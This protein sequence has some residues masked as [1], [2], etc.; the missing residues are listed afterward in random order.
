MNG[1]ISTGDFSY[2]LTFVVIYICLDKINQNKNQKKHTMKTKQNLYVV[3]MVIS[4]LFFTSCDDRYQEESLLKNDD[5]TDVIWKPVMSDSA[6][7]S[8]RHFFLVIGKESY[9][10]SLLKEYGLTLD[11]VLAYRQQQY[12]LDVPDTLLKEIPLYYRGFCEGYPVI[13]SNENHHVCCP[14]LWSSSKAM[15]TLKVVD[16]KTFDQATVKIVESDARLFWQIVMVLAF[17]LLAIFLLR[18]G[19]EIWPI[20]LVSSLVLLY[21]AV[22]VWYYLPY[23]VSGLLSLGF[24]LSVVW[25][26]RYPLGLKPMKSKK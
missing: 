22:L 18:I 17:L 5:I 13:I 8:I 3:I 10:P 15:F 25:F 23:F 9:A 19:Y 1:E 7:A 4:T 24:L 6:K 14:T 20:A 26:F 12:L 21:S 2:N 16:P 11:I